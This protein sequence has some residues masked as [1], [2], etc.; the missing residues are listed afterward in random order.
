MS[1][2]QRQDVTQRVL[3]ARIRLALQQPFL[4]TAVMRL[5]VRE[6]YELAWC[7]T[8]AMPMLLAM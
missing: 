3:R 1:P 2:E 7:P 4:A 8:A 6:V 5:P